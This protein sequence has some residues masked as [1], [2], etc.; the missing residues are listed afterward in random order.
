MLHLLKVYRDFWASLFMYVSLADATSFAQQTR[1]MCCSYVAHVPPEPTDGSRDRSMELTDRCDQILVLLQLLQHMASRDEVLGDE[2][3]T[4]YSMALLS[5]FGDVTARL[6]ANLLQYPAVCEAYFSLLSALLESQPSIA[7]ALP[8]PLD[9][10]TL[11]S[12]EFG[13]AHHQQSICRYALETIYEL[14]RQA[15]LRT[16][17]ESVAH[18]LRALLARLTKDLLTSRLHPDLVDPP[19][20]NAL[21]ALIVSQPGH[22]QAVVDAMLDLQPD[23]LVRETVATAFQALLTTNNVNASLTKPNRVRFRVNLQRLL[24]QM[25]SVSIRLPV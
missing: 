21:L 1:Q 4:A 19:A 13:L 9:A 12:I 2:N 25:Q 8:A 18:I 14:A 5:C 20:G 11:A 7:L 16:P 17:T 10:A 24:E 6:T 22:W 15:S 3:A 23:Q